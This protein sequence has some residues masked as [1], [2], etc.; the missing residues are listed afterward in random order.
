MVIFKGAYVVEDPL[1]HVFGVSNRFPLFGEV[2]CVGSEPNIFECSH[3]SIGSH[4]C[5]HSNPAVPDIIIS[6]YG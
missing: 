2:R 3:S 6:C 1:P 5:D 4:S